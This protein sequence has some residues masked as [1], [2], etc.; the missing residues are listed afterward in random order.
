MKKI[1]KLGAVA[2]LFKIRVSAFTALS[3]V[4][5]LLLENGNGGNAGHSPSRLAGLAAGVLLLASGAS[6]LN[7]FQE[8]GTDARMPRTRTRPI[9]SGLIRP[10]HALLL[11]LMLMQAGSIILFVFGGVMPAA[12]GGLAVLWYNLVYTPL[13]KITPFA[14]IP[15]ALAGAIAPAIG[16]VYNGGSLSDPKALI[17]CF[18][19]YI[20]QIPH[21]WLFLLKYGEEYEKAGLPSI[22]SVFSSRQLRRV[23]FVWDACTAA[24][25]MLLFSLH[26]AGSPLTC[27]LAALAAAW[28]TGSGAAVLGGNGKWHIFAWRSINACVLAITILLWAGTIL[29]A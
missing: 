9:P 24:S 20:W 5:G 19:F 23:I 12:L 14:V 26:A 29:P 1:K 13:K 18:F 28:I 4:T 10:A 11:S 6:A 22:T 25:A 3:S 16:W 2:G 21:F 8:A 17:V 7:Q 15:G 27:S